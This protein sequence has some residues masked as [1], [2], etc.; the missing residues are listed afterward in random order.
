MRPSFSLD[1]DEEFKRSVATLHCP[2]GAPATA[3]PGKHI[4]RRQIAE[5]N[6]F[7][8]MGSECK[9]D[10]KSIDYAKLT[11]CRLHFL[12]STREPRPEFYCSPCKTKFTTRLLSPDAKLAIGNEWDEHLRS[13]HPRQWEREQRK[14]SRRTAQADKKTMSDQ[15]F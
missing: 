6:G 14:T 8:T 10:V 5:K 3:N 4:T 7:R 13:V 9:G 11:S 1:S 2:S 15:F 12:G